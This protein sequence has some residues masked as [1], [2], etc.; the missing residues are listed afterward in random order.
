VRK[1]LFI[2]H[3]SITNPK[4]I[5]HLLKRWGYEID[6]CI[7]SEGSQLPFTMEN[8]EAAISF[9]GSMSANDGE[10]L[11]FI[12]TELDWIPTVLESGKP[13]LGICL[14]AQLLAH[15]LGAKV[16]RHP[17]GKV[18]I[19]YHPIIP[20]LAGSKYFD[21][22]LSFYHWNSEG[23]ELPS[24]AVK[25]ASG[26]MFEN[27]AFRYGEN[28]YGVQFHPEISSSVLKEWAATT[29][30]ET[31]QKLQLPGAQSWEEQI[32]RHSLYAPIVENW[33][34]TF[35]SLWLEKTANYNKKPIINDSATLA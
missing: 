33:L 1:I 5:T 12:R 11:P 14:G 29:D 18:E 9:G 17:E 31:E 10:T 4:P 30:K 32:E 26:E 21:A 15:S 20:T 24:D 28:A 35:L 27:Q 23:F 16:A 6:I 2:F 13:F 22:Q 25:L 34:D 7:P 3:S 19:G 8:H